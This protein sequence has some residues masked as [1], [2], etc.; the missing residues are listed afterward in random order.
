[1]KIYFSP[2]AKVKL[3]LYIRLSDA[4]VSGV[5]CVTRL[6][7]GSFLVDD[8][9]ILEQECSYAETA[10]DQKALVR[11]LEEFVAKGESPSA[12]RLWWH[13][14]GSFDVF[15]SR[16]DERTIRCFNTVPWL[17]SVVG[18]KRGEYRARLDVFDPAH[19]TRDGI[20]VDVYLEM[21]QKE[22]EAIKQELNQ[23]LCRKNYCYP[24]KVQGAWYYDDCWEDD[25]N[26]DEEDKEE[27]K[28]D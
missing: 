21:D 1:M 5:G 9:F 25:S 17:I 15:W 2:K 24:V 20:N 6:E 4:E 27:D 26:G 28:E 23:K 19:L 22:A 18:N 11:F 12:L 7:R 8:V 14:H 10:L 16:R 3:D 13:S